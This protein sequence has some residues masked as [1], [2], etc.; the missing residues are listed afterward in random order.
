MSFIVR[1][2]YSSVL[3][4]ARQQNIVKYLHYL[5]VISTLLTGV[6]QISHYISCSFRESVIHMR[7]IN[8]SSVLATFIPISVNRF[9]D[10]ILENQGLFYSLSQ[11]ETLVTTVVLIKYRMLFDFSAILIKVGSRYFNW[12][13]LFELSL[14]LGSWINCYLK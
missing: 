7:Y 12:A 11:F 3:P 1:D 5:N 6:R 13:G 10:A 14:F 9:Q 4:C 8:R 2:Y